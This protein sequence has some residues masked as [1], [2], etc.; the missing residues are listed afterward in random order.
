MSTLPDILGPGLFTVFCGINP[1]LSAAASGHHFVGRSNR[2]WPVLH[3]AGFTP[4]ILDPSDDAQLLAY[5]YGI[6]A[7]VPRATRSAI[8]VGVTDLRVGL[9]D[10]EEKIG[11]IRPRTIAFLGKPAWVVFSGRK[12][13][14][15]GQ[16]PEA[17]GG[18]EAWVLPN[19]SGLNRGFSL[20]DLVTAYSELRL[21]I[22]SGKSGV[23]AQ[24]GSSPLQ[25]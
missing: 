20:A 3:L 8:E 13:V 11:D 17:F 15:W 9:R 22:E 6:T 2:F 7:V 19:P 5:G 25:M 14:P 24:A 16:Q 18:V 12:S 21:A 10:L 23:G 4:F 1:G